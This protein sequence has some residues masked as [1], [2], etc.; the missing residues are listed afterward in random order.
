MHISAYFYQRNKEDKP[1]ST[2]H[3]YLQGMVRDEV[4]YGRDKEELI[5]KSNT[6]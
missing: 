2:E 6:L 5:W 4:I 1:E 3:D